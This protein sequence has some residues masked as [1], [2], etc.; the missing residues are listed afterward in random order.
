MDFPK[1]DPETDYCTSMNCKEWSWCARHKPNAPSTDISDKRS[2]TLMDPS[3]D[4]IF[5]VPKP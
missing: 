1:D 5:F 3:E 2:S 4:C